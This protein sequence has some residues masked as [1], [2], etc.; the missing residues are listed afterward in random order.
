MNDIQT[1]PIPRMRTASGIAREIQ[2]LD[3]GSEITTYY[4]R[5]L[6]K[7]GTIPVVKAGNKSLVDLNIVL[8]FLRQG[9]AQVEPEIINTNGIRRIDAKLPR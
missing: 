5:Q 9:T 3:P 1:K 2:V 8:E 7:N 4:I 6:I